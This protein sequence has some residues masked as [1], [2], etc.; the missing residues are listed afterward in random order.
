[1][2]FRAIVCA[3]LLICLAWLA[4]PATAAAQPVTTDVNADGLPDRIDRGASPREIVIRLSNRRRSQRLRSAQPI[5]AFAVADVDRDGDFDLIA[6]TAG[7]LTFE[8]HVWTNA[9]HGRFV[10]RAR[11][12]LP[13]RGLAH[14]RLG[15]PT[16]SVE[17]PVLCGDANR[18]VVLPSS[19]P[20]ACPSIAE[21]I[22]PADAFASSSV[23]QDRPR[24]RGPPSRSLLS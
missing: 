23:T 12:S 3:F 19:S 8:V 24:P 14:R 13:H 1:M 7:S 15:L 5:L 18:P 11:D 6:T 20:A 4:F 10:V 16:S 21:P 17:Q 9:G 22:A 2:S